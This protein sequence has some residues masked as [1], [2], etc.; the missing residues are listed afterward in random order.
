MRS[1]PLALLL[2]RLTVAI[3]NIVLLTIFKYNNYI[4]IQKPTANH[5]LYLRQNRIQM[6]ESFDNDDTYSQRYFVSNDVENRVKIEWMAPRERKH[7][8]VRI[9]RRSVGINRQISELTSLV[10]ASTGRIISNP[11]EENDMNSRTASYVESRSDI[12]SLHF[13][14]ARTTKWCP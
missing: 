5:S 13:G 12:D 8:K 1:K 10:R 14:H 2:L 3:V 9:V 11:G 4:P 6:D 7:E